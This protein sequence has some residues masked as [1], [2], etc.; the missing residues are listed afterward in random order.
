[1]IWSSAVLFIWLLVVVAINFLYKPAQQ[2]RKVAYL[3]VSSFLF[4]LLELVLVWGV[5]H[6]TG[7]GPATNENHAA[8]I[9]Q[10][11]SDEFTSSRL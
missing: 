10:E 8:V 2:G 1:V 5:G 11:D 3:M 6:A 7:T 4:L 9:Y